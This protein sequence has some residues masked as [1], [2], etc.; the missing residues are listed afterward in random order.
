M[1]SMKKENQQKKLKTVN[2]LK[3]VFN[4]ALSVVMVA[5]MF[6]KEKPLH[7]YIYKLVLKELGKGVDADLNYIDK[8]ITDFAGLHKSMNEPPKFESG[9]I[10]SKGEEIISYKPGDRTKF[11][12]HR[13][14]PPPPRPICG[15]IPVIGTNP[16]LKRLKRLER[17]IKKNQF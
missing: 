16:I 12:G 4:E 10:A 6:S 11:P 3:A 2:L 13:N 5:S 7:E 9:G 15:E 8:L 17:F 1:K 14:P